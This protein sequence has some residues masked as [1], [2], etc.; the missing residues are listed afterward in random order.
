MTLNDRH[1]LSAV[2]QSNIVHVTHI[3]FCSDKIT[4][5][6]YT[7]LDL[8]KNKIESNHNIVYK[9]F[10]TDTTNWSTSAGMSNKW[11]TAAPPSNA[12]AESSFVK[13]ITWSKLSWNTKKKKKKSGFTFRVQPSCSH[14]CNNNLCGI[15]FMKSIRSLMPPGGS[16]NT[17]QGLG[18]GK[19]N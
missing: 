14:W 15:N 13:A 3:A 17:S 9:R 7:F 10:V 18:T 1:L 5:V 4:T 12:T 19:H 8:E 2:I 16:V 6:Y 11:Q